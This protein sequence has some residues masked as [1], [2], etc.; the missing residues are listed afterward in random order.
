MMIKVKA[1]GR[2]KQDPRKAREFL[3]RVT[4]ASLSRR[5]VEMT[6]YS[7]SSRRTKRYVIEPLRVTCADGGI[8][9]SAWVPEYD[10]LRHFALERVQKLAVLDEHFE[11]RTLPPEP[12]AS[13][14]SPASW[15]AL[16]SDLFRRWDGHWSAGFA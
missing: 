8:Y 4:D 6:Y 12:F 11:L 2:R 15:G 5:R 14:R 9:I 16:L 1:S 3:T 7:A 13:S 10:E